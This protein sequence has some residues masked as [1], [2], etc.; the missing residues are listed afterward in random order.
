MSAIC[1]KASSPTPKKRTLFETSGSHVFFKNAP[2]CPQKPMHSQHCE[3]E[4]KVANKNKWP[5]QYK[6]SCKALLL[7]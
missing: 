5:E 7:V 4:Q 3:P 1:S 2:Y 6:Q